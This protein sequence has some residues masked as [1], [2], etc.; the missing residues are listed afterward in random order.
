MEAS[1]LTFEDKPATVIASGRTDGIVPY[2]EI[3]L[4]DMR[5]DVTVK[6]LKE[7]PAKLKKA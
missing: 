6:P 2:V 5:D 4:Q 3:T 7:I 1:D